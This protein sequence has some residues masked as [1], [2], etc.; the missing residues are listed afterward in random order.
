[1]C[2]D[3]EIGS[4][5]LGILKKEL[6]RMRF[7]LHNQHFVF[8]RIIDSNQRNRMQQILNLKV[9]VFFGNSNS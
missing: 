7:P 8:L 5:K 2:P 9:A 1:M 3:Q 4:N 6:S